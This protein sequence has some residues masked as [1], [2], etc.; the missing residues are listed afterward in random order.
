MLTNIWR[1]TGLC[2]KNTS[3]TYPR[4]S[5]SFYSGL[6]WSFVLI[7]SVFR[8]QVNLLQDKWA[9]SASGFDDRLK[10]HSNTGRRLDLLITRL[11]IVTRSS[12][13]RMR[14]V[15]F[16]CRQGRFLVRERQKSDK[17]NIFSNRWMSLFAERCC[18]DVSRNLLSH[19][20]ANSRNPRRVAL[21][22][23]N[24]FCFSNIVSRSADLSP[25]LSPE[26]R[27]ISRIAQKFACLVNRSG[28]FMLE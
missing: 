9:V 16:L 28:A 4:C 6:L 7:N 13:P 19:R 14:R 11:I 26:P 2:S 17:L 21:R 5:W 8:K 10:G 18:A 3:S 20:F 23:R 15:L 24:Y 25:D 27:I 1:K 12:P 22:A